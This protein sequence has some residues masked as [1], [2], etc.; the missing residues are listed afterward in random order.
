M[1]D[2]L[3]P[4]RRRLAL[5]LVVLVSVSIVAVLVAIAVTREPRVDPVAQDQPGPVLLVPGYGGS[6][7]S[8]G[9][10]AAALQAGGR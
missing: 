7:T 9:H 1:L 8:L 10:L 3:S 5:V 6:T 4:A 2:S